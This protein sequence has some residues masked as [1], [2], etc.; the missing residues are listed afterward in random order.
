MKY[1][2]TGAHGQLGREWCL[3][4]KKRGK[5]FTAYGSADFDITDNNMIRERLEQD[6]PNVVINCAAYT[7]VDQSEDEREKAMLINGV[8][9]GE[10]AK[11]CAERGIRLVH[12]STD[13][14]FPGRLSDKELFPNGYR[15][16]DPTD[17]INVY[18]ESKWAGEQAIRDVGGEYLIIRVAWLCGQYGS[19]FIKTILRLG[20]ERDEL[21]VVNDQ[22][23]SPTFA[24][25]VVINSIYLLENEVRGTIHIT[26]SGMLTWFDLT[27]KLIELKGLDVKVQPVST[28]E[29]PLK[30][31]RP[32][33]SK[34]CI[35]KLQGVNDSEIWDWEFGLKKLLDQL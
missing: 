5:V 29:F 32:H 16:E 1:L 23:G 12:Y 7:K 33:F 34:L 19:N 14:V 27:M 4:L 25:N 8:A 21:R 15:E 6:K 22:W 20:R 24:E 17:P 13:Y 11:E 9:V 10:L 28:A 30:A 31:K 18:G 26:T 3:Y 35:E 2:I